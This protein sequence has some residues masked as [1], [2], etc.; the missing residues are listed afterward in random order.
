MRVEA[1]RLPEQVDQFFGDEA[2]FRALGR[3]SPRLGA[4][5]QESPVRLVTSATDWEGVGEI[6]SYEQVIAVRNGEMVSQRREVDFTMTPW[7]A[8]T[9]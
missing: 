4:P 2:E 3:V 6:V 5:S 1:Q 8:L 9:K 7:V